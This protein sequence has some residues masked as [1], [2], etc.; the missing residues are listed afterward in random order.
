MALLKPALLLSTPVSNVLRSIFVYMR[1]PAA[2]DHK[3]ISVSVNYAPFKPFEICKKEV[4][5][6]RFWTVFRFNLISCALLWVVYFLILVTKHSN[7]PFSLTFIYRWIRVWE[8]VLFLGRRPASL[9]FLELLRPFGGRQQPV[10]L[11]SS[12]L[13]FGESVKN[14]A[15]RNSWPKCVPR[16]NMYFRLYC[17]LIFPVSHPC[18]FML[19]CCRRW[20]CCTC[21]VFLPFLKDSFCIS[22]SFFSPMQIRDAIRGREQPL[23]VLF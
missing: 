10:Q 5:I 2:V 22:C 14:I 16:Y 12:R 1:L 7:E 3:C 19:S 15:T 8:R 21:L 20:F 6:K 18:C 4:T 23:S 17:L 9:D 11:A 13:G